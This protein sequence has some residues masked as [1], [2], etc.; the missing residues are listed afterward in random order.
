MTIYTCTLLRLLPSSLSPSID[1]DLDDREDLVDPDFG[2]E[3]VDL[4]FFRLDFF[5]LLGRFDG[6]K[7]LN[8]AVDVCLP[9]VRSKSVTSYPK[10]QELV[11]AKVQHHQHYQPSIK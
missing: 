5:E 7:L 11:L 8:L 6:G 9:K 2:E 3:F 10:K 1:R 4:F